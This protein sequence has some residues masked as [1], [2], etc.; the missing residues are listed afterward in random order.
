MN[1]SSKVYSCKNEINAL[2]GVQQTSLKKLQ[3][4][5]TYTANKTFTFPTGRRPQTQ[6]LVTFPKRIKLTFVPKDDQKTI[7][8]AWCDVT[9]YNG[10]D[11]QRNIV[12]VN[13]NIDTSKNVSWDMIFMDSFK[14]GSETEPATVSFRA[15]CLALAE[16]T[17]S[18]TE[19]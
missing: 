19:Y 11:E 14:A 13:Q 2:K 4:K 9:S 1:I 10:R 17:I 3:T 18:I 8:M 12:C 16:G 7:A 6:E 15:T 5:Y